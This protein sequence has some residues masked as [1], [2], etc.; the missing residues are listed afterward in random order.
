VPAAGGLALGVD[1]QIA[2][3]VR[4]NDLVV[5]PE[6]G[7]RIVRGEV[8]NAG[9]AVRGTGFLSSK[10]G[11]GQYTVSF[12]PAFGA[13]PI[14]VPACLDANLVARVGTPNASAVN[15][16]TF[17]PTTQAVADSAFTFVAVSA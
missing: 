14:V 5:L 17:N 2:A 12:T 8:N 10:F 1:D 9:G 4:G 13:T 11:T 7:A 16:I 6:L 3:L 15:I